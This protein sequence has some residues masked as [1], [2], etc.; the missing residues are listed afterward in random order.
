MRLG[1]EKGTVGEIVA[2]QY[3]PF[4][5]NIAFKDPE[6]GVKAVLNGRA[7]LFMHD[8]PVIWWYASQYEAQGLT[9]LPFLITEEG[10]AWAVRKD[11]A[12]LLAGANRFIA[13]WHQDGR[14]KELLSR[15]LPKMQ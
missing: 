2:R 13:A 9:A 10:I 1:T 12:E 15:W 4:A 8:A 5:K 6:K 3:F 14:L 7:D 11:D